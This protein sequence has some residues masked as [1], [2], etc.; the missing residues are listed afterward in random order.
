MFRRFFHRAPVVILGAYLEH[1][2]IYC[3][4]L[5]LADGKVVLLNQH[6]YPLAQF[7]R[8][9]SRH[10]QIWA[11]LSDSEILHQRRA[12]SLLASPKEILHDI[13]SCPENYFPMAQAPLQVECVMAAANNSQDEL[14]YYDIYAIRKSR[15]ISYQKFFSSKGLKLVM[16]EPASHSLA[17]YENNEQQESLSMPYRF[18][19][20]A[21]LRGCCAGC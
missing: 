2:N 3:I 4:E 6:V 5:Q 8:H 1:N 15:I 14:Y 13:Y 21:A 17:R 20:G 16:L 7:D 11:S 19:M 18:A 12:F 10:Q 9:G